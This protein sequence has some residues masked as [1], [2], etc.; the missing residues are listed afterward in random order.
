MQHTHQQQPTCA[1]AGPRVWLHVWQAAAQAGGGALHARQPHEQLLQLP[2][3]ARQQQKQVRCAA[4]AP[5][6]RP[7]CGC[8]ATWRAVALTAAPR[9]LHTTPSHAPHT[10]SPHPNTHTHAS[11]ARRAPRRQDGVLP[12]ARAPAVHGGRAQ[13]LQ[14]VHA[15]AAKRART[16]GGGGGGGVAGG[17]PPPPGGA[18]RPRVLLW[19][20]GAAAARACSARGQRGRA[21]GAPRHAATPLTTPRAHCP[22]HAPLPCAHTHAHQAFAEI[23]ARSSSCTNPSQLRQLTPQAAVVGLFRDLRG[24]ATA[25]NTRRTYSLLFDWLVRR[26]GFG[27]QSLTISPDCRAS[28]PPLA[29]GSCFR[30]MHHHHHPIT[31]ATAATAAAANPPAVPRA[32]ARGAVLP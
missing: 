27:P 30:H 19:R 29:R 13:P 16:A 26:Q 11:H 5:A 6:A 24:I 23:S 32:H 21:R 9:L 3:A 20:G 25:T 17:P 2:G 1:R 4:R 12:H 14:D 28:A 31:T 15:A 8:G 7:Q 22:T 10:L 18:G